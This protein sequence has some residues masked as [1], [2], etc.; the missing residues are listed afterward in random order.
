MQQHQQN[1][2]KVV[3][4]SWSQVNWDKIHT[5][6][7]R[8]QKK[9]HR[10]K[11]G[12]NAA[13]LFSLAA[14]FSRGHRF[15]PVRFTQRKRRARGVW[16][17]FD[18]DTIFRLF[19]IFCF[20]FPMLFI[21]WLSSLLSSSRSFFSLHFRLRKTYSFYFHLWNSVVFSVDCTLRVCDASKKMV[22]S[23]SVWVRT[24]FQFALC[25]CLCVSVNLCAI[26]LFP[27]PSRI[28]FVFLHMVFNIAGEGAIAAAFSLRIFHIV[29]IG[30]HFT[31]ATVQ[32]IYIQFRN[33]IERI[34]RGDG[35]RESKHTLFLIS[36]RA[37]EKSVDGWLW[38]KC[39]RHSSFCAY[40]KIDRQTVYQ[41]LTS[42]FTN[43]IYIFAVF[44]SFIPSRAFC[45]IPTVAS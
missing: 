5:S 12:W 32:K 26:H 4:T 24:F 21:L 33:L 41:I 28:W 13:G 23:V 29:H 6:T 31:F 40:T 30:L 38:A 42:A 2:K 44:Y 8:L 11:N 34:L 3:Q 14:K 27:I 19:L 43:S 20:F 16:F 37:G 18:A 7:T 17:S 22:I 45:S 10:R 39:C 15:A 36:Y 9:K 25:V 1:G 35:G